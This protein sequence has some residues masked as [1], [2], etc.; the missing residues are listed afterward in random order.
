MGLRF[1][2]KNKGP[3]LPKGITEEFV[4][5][6]ETM[7][8]DALKGRIVS[9]QKDLQDCQV[10]LDTKKEIVDMKAELK[11]LTGPTQE[12]MTFLKNRTKHVLKLL[13][14]KGAL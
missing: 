12:T 14:D 6:V 7:S 11:L 9:M 5:E 10:F 4:A 13:G 2:K 3:K 1:G 8:A